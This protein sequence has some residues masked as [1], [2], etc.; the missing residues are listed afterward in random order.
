MSKYF[1][2]GTREYDCPNT[3][4][5]AVGG[6]SVQSAVFISSEILVSGNTNMWIATGGNPTAV[7]DTDGNIYL[8]AGVP[9]HMRVVVGQRLAVIQDS[10]AGHVS[11][12]PC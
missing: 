11:V 4:V 8:A 6:A 7:A 9:L 5:I 2:Q 3:D 1:Q 10:A 12:T